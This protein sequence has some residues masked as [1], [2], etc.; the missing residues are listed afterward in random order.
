MIRVSWLAG[1]QSGRL[2]ILVACLLGIIHISVGCVRVYNARVFASFF[3]CLGRF[4]AL[5]VCFF[6][7]KIP[8][9]Y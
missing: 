7:E 2:V 3:V 9:G 8:P 6:I 5:N 1:L 4:V